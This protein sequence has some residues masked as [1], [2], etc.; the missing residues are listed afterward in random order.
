[1]NPYKMALRKKRFEQYQQ[2]PEAEEAAV[3]A[4]DYAP[5][6]TDTPMS[7]EPMEM[8]ALGPMESE[9]PISDDSAMEFVQSAN[10]TPGIDD[11]TVEEVFGTQIPMGQPKTLRDRV[12][13]QMKKKR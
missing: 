3:Q 13:Q 6:V 8:A 11:L 10:E 7:E 2:D 5:E 4:G 9:Q 12:M 1:M